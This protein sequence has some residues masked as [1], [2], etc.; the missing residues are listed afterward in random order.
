MCTYE[1]R[2]QCIHNESVMYEYVS[3][4]L[5]P[6][7]NDT[8]YGEEKSEKDEEL[9]GLLGEGWRSKCRLEGVRGFTRE[10]FEVPVG[11]IERKEGYRSQLRE[12]D[13]G[14]KELINK[15]SSQVS[16]HNVGS[17]RNSS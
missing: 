15:V 5:R 7:I 2:L 4:N 16:L 17:K 1:E 8:V 9:S 11:G 12:L 10:S 3:N 6:T 14:A 13:E